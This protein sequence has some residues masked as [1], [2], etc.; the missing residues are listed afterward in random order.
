[1]AGGF[2][3]GTQPLCQPDGVWP[4]RIRQ[5]ARELFTSHSAE[6][7][8]RPQLRSRQPTKCDEHCVT[9]KVPEFV[10]DALEA[11]EIEREKRGRPVDLPRLI[12][13]PA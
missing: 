3:R 10:I 12:V 11:I 6:Q 1:V 4:R 2:E 7:I 13:R 8:R 5:Q 9:G